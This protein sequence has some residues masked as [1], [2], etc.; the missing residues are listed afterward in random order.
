MNADDPI[1]GKSV[2]EDDT[3]MTSV[4]NDLLAQGIQ[5]DE[6]GPRL[7]AMFPGAI[8]ESGAQLLNGLKAHAAEML[9]DR[10]KIRRGFQKRQHEKWGK[11][12]DLLLML[13]EAARE[14]GEE[15]NA[16]LEASPG[17]EDDF[18]FDALRRLHARGC[19][20]T[21][22]ILCL[23]EG[24]YASG[25]MARWRT[26]HEM[27][28]VGY[29]VKEHGQDVAERYLWHHEADAYRAAV[30]INEHATLLGSEPFPDLE[31]RQL[32]AQRDALCQRFGESYKEDWGWAA[33]ALKPKRANFAE[34][35]K[36]VSLGH[37]RP[38]FKLASHGNHAGS[39]GIWFDLGNSLNAPG[40][41]VMLAGPS[42]AGLADPGMCTAISLL[43]LT[44]NLILYR[45]PKLTALIVA[46][47]LNQLTNEIKDAF[48]TAQDEL[49]ELAKRMQQEQ[50]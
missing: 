33:E 23:V 13:M 48:V 38:Y 8:V 25:A 34:I 46:E 1:F 47:C 37:Y 27:A 6:I 49:T 9:A 19:L 50:V 28:V 29:F 24:G 7:D 45:N 5:P 18:V 31:L 35:E 30:Q 43:Q 36:A 44:T 39:K 3:L 20:L 21:S 32:Q 42:D 41:E 12:L 26:L 10:R 16:T 4:I 40:T 17:S 22:E 14:S 15:Y 2:E 11:P